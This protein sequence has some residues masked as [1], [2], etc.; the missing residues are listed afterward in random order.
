MEIKQPQGHRLVLRDLSRGECK[1]IL[2]TSE[3]KKPKPCILM[4][5]SNAKIYGAD[6]CCGSGVKEPQMSCEL[7]ESSG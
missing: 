1:H 2:R 6:P 4:G 7:H 5:W 3:K